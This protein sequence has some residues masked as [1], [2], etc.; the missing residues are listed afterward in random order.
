ME[1]IF[2]QCSCCKKWFTATTENFNKKK[3]SKYN[4]ASYCKQCKYMKNKEYKNKNK[5]KY[6][7]YFKKYREQNRDKHKEYMKKYYKENKDISKEYGKK[8]RE[9]H[10]DEMREYSKKYR[11]E[12]KEELQHKKRVYR[13]N[14]R[15]EYNN[16]MKKYRDDNPDKFFNKFQKQREYKNNDEPLNIISR[17]DWD[18]LFDFFNNRCAYTGE[19]LNE[20]NRTVDHIIPISQGG[21]NKLNNLVPCTRSANS[22]KNN[23]YMEDWFKGKEFFS[24]ERLNKIYEWID[25]STVYEVNPYESNE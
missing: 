2:K 8:Y 14:H 15:Q 9:E 20:Y 25:I 23:N 24:E 17:E 22:S 4:L 11:E 21:D 6:D 1:N 16:Y 18:L 12:H 3:S 7:E 5:E 19:L 10:K 13:E